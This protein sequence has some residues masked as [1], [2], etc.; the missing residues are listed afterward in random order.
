MFDIVNKR[1]PGIHRTVNAAIEYLIDVAN[2]VIRLHI[3][4]Y[5]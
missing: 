2:Y 5:L 4:R 3:D 1:K